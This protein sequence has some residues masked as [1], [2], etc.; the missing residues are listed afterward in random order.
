M[1]LVLAW[2]LWAIAPSAVALTQIELSDLRYEA[3]PPEL[4]QG[5]VTS[6]GY[7]REANCFLVTGTAR[8]DTG[9]PV[10][11]ADV[12]GRIYDANRNPV[13]PNRTRVGTIERIPPGTSEFSIRITVPAGQ[14]T[15]LQLEQFEASGFSGSVEYRID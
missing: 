15:P 7:S 8:N 14:P 10:Y 9:Q 11:D 1:A 12:Y 5:A 2:A 3:C 13:M 6:G 4:A